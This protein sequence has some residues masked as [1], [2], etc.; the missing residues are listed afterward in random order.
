M[1][2]EISWLNVQKAAEQFEV[3]G[4][5]SEASLEVCEQDLGWGAAP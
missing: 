2:F 1:G 3:V 5:G 4:V